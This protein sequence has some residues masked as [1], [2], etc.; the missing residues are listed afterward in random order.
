[1]RQ[2]IR[3]Q[4]ERKFFDFVLPECNLAQPPT[5]QAM[6][7][8]GL[9]A[10]LATLPAQAVFA[11]HEAVAATYNDFLP[12]GKHREELVPNA[13]SALLAAGELE[14]EREHRGRLNT[15]YRICTPE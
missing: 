9:R 15:I 8:H 7:V 13:L 12:Q 5:H 11:G 2:M 10:W 14:V 3:S 6:V 1:M 4:R